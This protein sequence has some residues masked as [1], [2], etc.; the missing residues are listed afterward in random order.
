MEEEDQNRFLA[1]DEYPDLGDTFSAG[2]LPDTGLGALHAFDPKDP[3]LAEFR[4]KA[5][6]AS[7]D[8]AP[9]NDEE[10]W[11]YIRVM[12]GIRVPRVAPCRHHQSVFDAIADMFFMRYP[13][14]NP[15]WVGGRGT[16][17]T[18]GLAVLESLLSHFFHD[19]ISHVGGVEEQAKKCYSYVQRI[20]QSPIFKAYVKSSMLSR[21]KYEGG[22]EIEIMPATMNRVNSPHPRIACFDEVDLWK[23][24]VLQ[25]ALSMPVRTNGRPPQIIFTSSLK[26]R[27][28]PMVRLMDSGES[29]AIK[30]YTFCVFEVIETCPPTRHKGGEGCMTCP[31][32]PECLDSKINEH[33]E[34]EYEPGPGKASRADGGYMPIDDVIKK[35]RGLDINIWRSQWRCEKPS[36]EG[37]VYPQFDEAIHVI[38]Y[39]WNR[40]LPV[41]GGYD[42]GY[43]NAS[44]GIYAQTNGNDEIIIFAENYAN[45]RTDVE[46]AE[47]VKREPWFKTTEWRDGDPAAATA[48][49]EF[50]NRGVPIRPANNTKDL[51][52]DDSGISKVRWALS[53]PG[54][55]R[56]ILYISRKCVNTI[57]EMKSY[58]FQ[59]QSA[60]ADRNAREETAKVDDHCM[61]AMRYLI[62][63]L[64]PNARKSEKRSYDA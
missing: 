6:S 60:T 62:S 2:D 14:Y 4:M 42:F 37:L 41:Y 19:T 36:A 26:K 50:I 38:D 51:S 46:F 32:A 27:Y 54:R 64:I 35:F 45:L 17:K 10:L 18:L 16:G 61:D 33:G 29:A 63:R 44:V 48:R 34:K 1:D 43:V 40:N 23:W 59:E 39:E 52:K 12:M 21:T 56:P 24:P 57:R 31:L 11:E 28:G 47:S 22:G 20:D 15:L 49:A 55:D 3:H 8:I 30:K 7:V 5:M 25:E 53:P 58:H 13:E 9:T